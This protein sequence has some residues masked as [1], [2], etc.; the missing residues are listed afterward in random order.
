[1]IQLRVSSGH[2]RKSQRTV[3]STLSVYAL[4]RE[5]KLVI[6]NIPFYQAQ[7][8]RGSRNTPISIS[9]ITETRIWEDCASSGC[10]PGW[11]HP[12]SIL[13]LPGFDA[14][15]PGRSTDLNVEAV[16]FLETLVFTYQTT[17]RYIAQIIKWVF[18]WRENLRPYVILS[19]ASRRFTCFPSFSSK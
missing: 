6:S 13:C 18:H 14:I 16:Y 10:S 15:Q 3:P 19:S 9:G 7:Q 12:L 11:G 8:S 17:W 5:L 1:M 4:S 2:S